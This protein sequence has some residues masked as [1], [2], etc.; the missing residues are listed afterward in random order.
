MTDGW[1]CVAPGTGELPLIESIALLQ[2]H[3]Y[4]DWLLFEH[5]KRWHPNLP[6]P[7]EIFPQFVEWVRPFIV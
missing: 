1:H 5:E 2:E 3:G 6:E 7:E 4:N